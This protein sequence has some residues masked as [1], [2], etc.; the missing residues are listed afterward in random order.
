MLENI[1]VIPLY[2][3]I[4]RITDSKKGMTW[5]QQV[6]IGTDYGKA[7][8]SAFIA[9][10]EEWPDSVTELKSVIRH[11]HIKA[12]GTISYILETEV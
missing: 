4:V 9:T 5:E 6:Y 12:D 3:V 7:H 8:G 2:V 10:Q 11:Y 1:A